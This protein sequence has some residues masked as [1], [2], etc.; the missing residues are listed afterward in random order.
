M[1]DDL[2]V[3]KWRRCRLLWSQLRPAPG[4]PRPAP[5]APQRPRRGPLGPARENRRRWRQRQQQQRWREESEGERDRRRGRHDDDEEEE[6][7]P[8]DGLASRPPAPPWEG[9]VLRAG[10]GRALLLLPQPQVLTFTGKCQVTCLYGRVQVFGFTISPGQRAYN[11]FSSHTHCALSIEAVGYSMPEKTKKEMRTEAR[12]LLKAHLSLANRNQLMKEFS[13]LCSIVLLEHLETSVTSFILSHLNFANIF[14]KKKQ[15]NT[16]I[17]PEDE[18]L[19]SVGISK[20]NDKSGFYLSESSISA[21]E[22]L[23]YVCR[24]EDDGCPVI[25]TCGAKAVGKSTFNRYLINQLLNSIPCVDYLEC[26][27]GQTEFT[28]PG[29]ISLL[30]VTE[31]LLGPPFTH[32]RA[33][34]KMVYY[35][36]THCEEDCERY[37]EIV[38]YVF[39]SY[40]REAPLIINTMGWVKGNGLLLLID[41]IRLLSPSHVVQFSADA[42]ED[43]PSLSPEYIEVTSGLLTRGKPQVKNKSLGFSEMEGFELLNEERGFQAAV[44]GHKLY[45]VHSEFAAAGSIKSMRTRGSILRD[46]AMLGYLG[47]LQ[48]LEPKPVFPLHSLIPYQVPFNA[49]ALQVIHTHVAPTHI[50][51]AFNASWVGLCRIL[52]EVKRHNSGPILLTQTPVCDCLGFGIV[53][54][55]DMEKR[56]YLIL[57]PVPPE[58]LRLVNCLLVGNVVLPQCVF[59]NQPGIEGEIP[60]VTS[61]YNFEIYGSEKIR[62]LQL[63]KGSDNRILQRH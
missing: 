2:F 26:D 31:P 35:G 41:L 11:L 37:I 18:V 15:K 39:N 12:E 42:C 58:K 29:C 48:P 54:G 36:E 20:C 1:A 28:P 44:T 59:K 9:L 55:I 43:L 21:I 63:Q 10:E 24:E 14:T 56:L 34:R 46:M 61:E 33:P 19:A 8:E 53:R 40:K 4:R 3:S 16:C 45:F 6:D 27:L 23:I 17:S 62:D 49:V 52:D 32:Q 51:Y 13:P 60:Y 22:E 38:K 30:T 25:L 50:L 5:G 7:E 47:Q 57:T